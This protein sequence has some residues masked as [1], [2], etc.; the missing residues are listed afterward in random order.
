MKSVVGVWLAALLAVQPPQVF[1]SSVEVVEI[2]VS[3]MRGNQP[4]QGLTSSDF[5]LTDNGVAQ[6]VESV[7]VDRLPLNVTLVLDAS[8]S[9]YGDRLTHLVHPGETFTNSLRPYAHATRL[10]V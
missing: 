5:T 9:L 6:Q 4:V 1:R 3:V 10:S 8:R 7:L 2:D